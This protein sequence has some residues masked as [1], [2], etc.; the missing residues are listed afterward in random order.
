MARPL[1]VLALAVLLAAPLAA[2]PQ[3]QSVSPPA[4]TV[5]TGLVILGSGFGDERPPRAWLEW[6]GADGPVQHRLKILAFS[7]GELLAQVVQAEPGPARLVLRVRRWPPL[8]VEGAFTGLLPVVGDVAPLAA[9]PGDVVTLSGDQLGSR[10]V[11]VFLF[12]RPCKVVSAGDDA[13]SFR[14]PASVPDGEWTPRV[15]NPLGLAFAPKVLVVSGSAAPPP[16]ERVEALVGGVPFLA[17]EADVAAANLGTKVAFDAFAYPAG[18]QQHLSALLAFAP[19]TGKL[20]KLLGGTSSGL[21]PLFFQEL[22]LTNSPAVQTFYT[23]SPATL[24]WQVRFLGRSG[25]LLFG[26]FEAELLRVSGPGPDTLAIT[27]GVFVLDY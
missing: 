6:D 25:G 13:V 8:V 12:D 27:D 18:K 3:V 26:L 7:D 14:V 11:K 20:P 19:A 1:C 10:R 24:P 15:E 9:A 5:G 23:A 16:V 2:Q 17:G 21:E 22:L 4:G